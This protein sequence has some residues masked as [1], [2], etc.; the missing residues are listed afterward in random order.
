VGIRTLFRR[1]LVNLLEF[2]DESEDDIM[3]S[4]DDLALLLL[5]QFYP[6]GLQGLTAWRDKYVI[7]YYLGR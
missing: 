2:T 5:A 1:A 7:L 6:Q 4:I 3:V